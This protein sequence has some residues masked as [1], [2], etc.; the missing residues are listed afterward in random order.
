MTAI[1]HT[2]PKSAPSARVPA[3]AEPHVGD[4]EAVPR[5]LTWAVVKR[6]DPRLPNTWG[7][8]WIELDGQES[9][10]WWPTPCP[11]GWRGALSGS[12]GCLNGMDGTGG[13]SATRDAYHGDEP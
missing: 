4:A 8:W 2:M 5:V 1:A 6:I 9:Y 11:M 13:G 7:H 3:P 10:G 12:R